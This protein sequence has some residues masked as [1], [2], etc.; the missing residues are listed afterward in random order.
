MPQHFKNNGYFA[1]SIGKIYHGS[2]KTAYV[3]GAFQDP[4]SWSAERW[5]A[6]PQ[7]YFS[8]D[9]IKIAREIF[10]TA[11][12]KFLFLG[13]AKRDPDNPDQWK[14][15]FVR[16]PVTEA[17]DVPDNL[18][19]DGKIAEAA[20][21]R[22]R[23]LRNRDN[24][25]PFF[26]AVGFQK[27][28]LPFVAPKKY[29]DLY[30]PE[31]LPPVKVTQP[32][33]GAPAFSMRKGPAELNQYLETYPGG[34]VSPERTRHLRHGYAACVSYIDAQIGLLLE[35]LDTQGIRDNTI[36][37]LWSDHGYKLGDLGSWAKHTNFELDTRVPL[38]ISAPGLPP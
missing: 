5:A 13:D 26:L 32:P 38:I 27:P 17:P 14:D 1:Q 18:P 2:W 15:F 20:L 25:P 3:G 19:A 6:S 33:E 21:D 9:G 10:A 29:W 34:V 8:P 37:V 28:H 23:E 24:A 30:D 36:V 7:Y 16:G 31:K 22:L 4:V 35:E 11:P 12:P